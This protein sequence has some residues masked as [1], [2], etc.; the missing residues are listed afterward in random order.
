VTDP[1]SFPFSYFMLVIEHNNKLITNISNLKFLG[2][3]IDNTSSWKGH[4]DKLVPRLS[5]ACYVIRSVKTYLLQYILRMIY[6]AYFHLVVTDGQ[7]FWGNSS[8]SMEVFR[9]QK[10][11]IGV[12]MRTRSRDSYRELF[13]ILGILPWTAQQYILWLCLLSIMDSI[14]QRILNYITLKLEIT[15]TYFSHSQIY[16]SVGSSLC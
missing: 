16:P 5:Q 15:G 1:V 2:I 3:M 12:V 6:Y 10:K 11:I 13:Q 8:H 9:L 4:I 14:S 7:L